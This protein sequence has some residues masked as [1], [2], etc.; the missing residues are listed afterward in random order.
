MNESK[1]NGRCLG[2]IEDMYLKKSS[3]PEKTRCFVNFFFGGGGGR[4]GISRHP[5]KAKC[6]KILLNIKHVTE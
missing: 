3:K 2:K 1:L 6:H 5:L 4:G